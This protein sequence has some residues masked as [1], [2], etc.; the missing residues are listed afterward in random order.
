[1]FSFL[2][3]AGI[4]SMILRSQFAQAK[5]IRDQLRRP[6]NPYRNHAHYGPPILPSTRAYLGPR[7]NR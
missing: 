6:S 4:G 5:I 2:I 7:K 3:L 1:M